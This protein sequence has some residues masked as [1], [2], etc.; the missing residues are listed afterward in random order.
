[1]VGSSGYIGAAL[2]SSLAA[3]G[4]TVSGSSRTP[5]RA[6]YLVTTAQDLRTLL[7]DHPFDQVVFTP[8]LAGDGVDALLSLVDG[9]RWLVFSSAQLTSAVPAPGT[10]PALARE[11]EALD[12]GATV[13]RPTMVFG[14]GGDPSLSR[15]TR[16]LARWHVAV[17]IGDG[18]QLVQPVH[19]D[20][21]GQ[22]AAAHASAQVGGLFGAGGADVATMREVVD[23]IRELVGVPIPPLRV[24]SSWLRRV[25]P[26]G[27][28][29]LRPDQ[30]LRL[31]EDKTI[32]I[33]A[34]RDT[35]GWEPLP[36]GQRI[37]QAVLEALQPE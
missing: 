32:D 21:L 10:E 20:D 27:I 9:P 2:A 5:A 29:G 8:Q 1:M 16:F 19:V 35:F 34:T 3:A 33:S 30:V 12:R 14:R 7:A 36:L 37:E 4:H 17:Q 23:M 28:G 18:D 15:V 13:V 31:D 26:L 11:Q 24:R 25:A 22:L 6:D